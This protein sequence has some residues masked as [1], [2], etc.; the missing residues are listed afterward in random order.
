VVL[1]WVILS[2]SMAMVFFWFQATC[3]KILRRQFERE[4]FQFVANVIRLEFPSLRLSL[5]E[6][7]ASFDYSRLSRM[8]KCDFLALMYLLKN[9]ANGYQSHSIEERL[10]TLYFRWELLSLAVR[11]QLKVGEKKAV[12]RLTSVL[13]YFANVVGQHMNPVG[14]AD[15][16]AAG[17]VPNC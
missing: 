12:L 13:K 8:L 5:A 2:L 11:C 1:A 17:Y 3:Q 15:L 6:S 9:V 7:E 14:C 4:Y 10:L 16:T